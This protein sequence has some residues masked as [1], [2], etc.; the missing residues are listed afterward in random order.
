M[1][2]CLFSQKNNKKQTIIANYFWTSED[3]TTC[4]LGF[5]RSPKSHSPVSGHNPH[6]RIYSQIFGKF[7]LHSEPEC[8]QTQSGSEAGGLLKGP[9][10][11]GFTRKYIFINHKVTKI[12]FYVVTIILYAKVRSSSTCDWI[13]SEICDV[14]A[15]GRIQGHTGHHR[16]GING[17]NINSPVH[18]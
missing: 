5:L 10:C 13:C 15:A 2:H 14:A 12:E 11:H 9:F 6:S 8:C 16:T 17:N 4:P 3:H 1:L 7:E 18:W